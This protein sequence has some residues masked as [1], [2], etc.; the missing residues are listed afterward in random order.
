MKLTEFSTSK[1]ILFPCQ[2]DSCN[3]P[4]KALYDIIL[5]SDFMAAMKIDLQYSVNQIKWDGL[6][7]PMRSDGSLT[8]RDL[9]EAIHFAH[10]QPPLLQEIEDRQ[11]RILDADYSKVDIDTMV[12]QLQ[13]TRASKRQLKR[14]LKKFPTLFGGGLGTVNIPPVTIELQKGAKPYKGRYY[15]VPKAYEKHLKTEINRMCDTT[16]LR[17]PG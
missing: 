5:G 3:D 17:K 15:S 1:E 14:T 16:V 13:I 7:I 2:I 8:N 4:K 9:A 12:D 10:T 11:Q 6:A